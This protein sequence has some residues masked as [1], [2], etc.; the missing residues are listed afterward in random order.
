MNTI[1]EYIKKNNNEFISKIANPLWDGHFSSMAMDFDILKNYS[2]LEVMDFV[3]NT[4]AEM[5]ANMIYVKYKNEI[6][7]I[8]NILQQHY[9]I[10]ENYNRLDATVNTGDGQSENNRITGSNTGTT[11]KELTAGNTDITGGRMEG[12]INSTDA[13]SK[14]A[15][16]SDTDNISV[17]EDKSTENEVNA[18]NDDR[19]ESVIRK[20][21]TDYTESEN[22][23]YGVTKSGEVIRDNIHVKGAESNKTNTNNQ[24]A[25]FNKK[26]SKIEDDNKNNNA[27]RVEQINGYDETTESDYGYNTS[28]PSITHKTKN[29]KSGELGDNK[30]GSDTKFYTT[31]LTEKAIE[32]TTTDRDENAEV[33][34]GETTEA[35]SGY[36]EAEKEKEHY[37]NYKE[38]NTGTK[39]VTHTDNG[40]ETNSTDAKSNREAVRGLTGNNTR[41]EASNGSESTITGEEHNE[42]VSGIHFEKY[43]D[44]ADKTES[45]R[46]E[47]NNTKLNEAEIINTNDTTNSMMINHTHGN[48]G[49]MTTQNMLNQEYDFWSKFNFPNYITA[50]FID[51]IRGERWL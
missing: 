3:Y 48:I 31:R 40:G 46:A 11:S 23:E 19:T 26:V 45:I 51:E 39:T 22:T 29:V 5:V 27:T 30:G 14:Q 37:N 9:N 10:I 1:G 15:V 21:N 4:P 32:T 7:R 33:N 12:Q 41:A 38:T 16:I 20:N 34:K 6:E 28:A 49:V 44:R 8:F 2:N 17:N 18:E 25:N 43:N 24:N 50:L 47:E 42:D 35:L 36:G 13:K